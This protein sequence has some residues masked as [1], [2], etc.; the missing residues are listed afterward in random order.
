M[1]NFH[2]QLI[3]GFSY[4]AIAKYSGLIVSLFITTILARKLEPSD[5]GTVSIAL[6]IINFFAILSDIGLAPAIIQRKDLDKEDLSI[7]FSFTI[8]AGFLFSLIFF[9]ISPFISI[10]Y[11]NDKLDLICKILSIN[12]IFISANIVPN[13]LLQ[14]D[15]RFRFIAIRTLIVQ[16]ICGTISC[17]AVYIGIGIYSL[18]LAPLFSSII[19]FVV[20]IRQYKLHLGPIFR[21]NTFD[22]VASYST[23][24]FSYNILSYFV[25]N[26]D[27]LIIGRIIGMNQLGLY[28]KSYQLI[29]LPIATI[30]NIITPVL[31]PVLSDY[32]NSKEKIYKYNI[33]FI[34][35]LAY[36]GFPIS[37]L[38]YFA[39]KE[40][41]IIL[42]GN[43]WIE[44][45]PIFKILSLSIGWQTVMSSCV[46][47]F[48]ASN[49]TKGLLLA[50]IYNSIIILISLF[51]SIIFF[52]TVESIAWAWVI[53]RILN[54][55]TTYWFLN[56]QVLNKKY[57][58]FLKQLTKPLLLSIILYISLTVYEHFFMC[59][60]MF[61]S[62]PIKSLI[63]FSII[64]YTIYNNTK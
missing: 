7:I 23:W 8:I 51:I 41:I 2:K 6:I 55:M 12:I 26:I 49:S 4:T 31:H 16:I 3:I 15:K 43:Q 5:F 21:K 25:S 9:I 38:L 37:I 53:S 39:A 46:A 29:Q 47:F 62:L 14:R 17:I 54:L 56:V 40:I 44:A 50:G 32:Q 58:D 34:K 61:I 19:L 11:E 18:L 63:T 20:N 52:S 1:Q 24:Q 57:L 42:F 35:I 60:N 59:E 45:I 27:K 28:D 13:G 36:I 48:Q 10:Y 64:I 30:T 33:Q 22:K